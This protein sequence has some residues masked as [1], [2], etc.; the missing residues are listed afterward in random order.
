M[1]IDDLTHKKLR[2]DDAVLSAIN[3]QHS[4]LEMEREL[5]ELK[6]VGYRFM[7]PLAATRLFYD[8]YRRQRVDYVRTHKSI[9]RA[10]SL[11]KIS[12]ERFIQDPANFAS[13]W[14]A[15][16]AADTFGVPYDLYVEFA[17]WFWSRRSGRGRN[18]APQIN[19]LSYTQKSE[20]YWRT[21]FEKFLCNQLWSASRALV[22]VPQL[23]PGAF[24]GTAEQIAAQRFLLELCSKSDRRWSDCLEMWCHSY[25]LLTPECFASIVP[26]DVLDSAIESVSAVPHTSIIAPPP[27]IRSELWP[28]CHGMPGALESTSETC[29]KCRFVESCGRLASMVKA[30]VRHRTG[31]QEPRKIDLR[32]PANARQR[33]Y[34]AR[35]RDAARA[36]SKSSPSLSAD[37]SMPD[38]TSY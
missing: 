9:E 32:K 23:H 3:L 25:P 16:Q 6:W 8:T 27:L 4:L 11:P 36:A 30:E 14:S 28:S 38:V 22:E 24:E 21:E 2:F 37:S 10:D 29:A 1:G 7:T 31:H 13:A 33:R 12:F 20:C 17:L 15:R 5:Q 35:M 34:R 18:G 26:L 19:Q